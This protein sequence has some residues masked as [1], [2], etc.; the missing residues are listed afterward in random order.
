[1]DKKYKKFYEIGNNRYY[2]LPIEDEVYI[3]TETFIDIQGKLKFLKPKKLTQGLKL[4]H[5]SVPISVLFQEINN[6][7]PNKKQDDLYN[8][9][10][11]C[12]EIH[13]DDL[14][15]MLRYP[16][17]SEKHVKNKI[18]EYYSSAIEETKKELNNWYKEVSKSANLNKDGLAALKERYE[19][20]LKLLEKESPIHK[21]I[22]IDNIDDTA[23]LVVKTML[24]SRDF[25]HLY[26]HKMSSFVNEV[27]LYDLD[28]FG[29]VT[30]YRIIT[31]KNTVKSVD[32]F[33][34][35]K[36]LIKSLLDFMY[37]NNI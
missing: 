11:D 36:K 7:K 32:S 8:Y 33:I 4:L 30:I 16:K 23:P 34:Y 5:L 19:N 26:T 10:S 29:Q 13:E 1:M 31:V 20:N 14:Q 15:S 28:V 17:L 22:V 25:K 27:Y 2:V 3:A 18:F 9:M 12:K 21:D 24:K 37:E 6:L 35:D